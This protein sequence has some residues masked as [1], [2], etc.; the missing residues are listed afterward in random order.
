MKKVFINLSMLFAA[1]AMIV[2][3]VQCHNASE[4]KAG[5]KDATSKVEKKDSK[6]LPN[7]RYVDSDSVLAK[8][9]LAKDYNEEMLRMQSNLEST[10]KQ[11]ESSLNNFLGQM[12][13][14]MQNSGYLSEQ[15]Y[16]ADQQK[17]AQMQNNAQTELAKM[18]NSMAQSAADAQKIIE[19]SV[20]SFIKDYNAKHGYDAIF[21][22]NATMYIDPAL[23][24]TDEVVEGLNARYNK[25][26]K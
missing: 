14:K 11:R 1:A 9:N 23:D 26:K 4:D 18:Q 13:Q 3:L 22:K 20:Q 5:Q 19:D 7:Y 21:Y 10:M 15:A 24:I 12:K 17:A 16:N 2:S 6:T 25:V 8:Y